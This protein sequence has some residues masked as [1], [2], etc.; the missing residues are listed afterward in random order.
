M[1]TLRWRLAAAGVV[2]L[3]LLALA[4]SQLPG[5]GAGALLHPARRRVGVPPPPTCENERIAGD[6]V[7]LAG[8]RCRASGPRRG[9]LVYLHGVADNRA[10]GA[11]VIE[12]FGK[13]GFDV[14]A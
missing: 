6:G 4:T 14:V 9:T 13:R 12:R 7:S 5:I 3:L 1:S 8:W 2:A 11:G 10:S